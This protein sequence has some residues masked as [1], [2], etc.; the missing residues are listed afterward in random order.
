ML[1][2]TSIGPHRADWTIGFMQAPVREMFSRGQEKLVVLACLLA[3]AAAFASVRGQWPVLLLDDLPSELD[4]GHLA[5]TLDWLAAIPVQ[6]FITGTAPLTL[7][8]SSPRETRVFHVEQ[9]QIGR[10]L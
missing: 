1:G 8:A 9:G 3:Q 10:L 5:A 7:P 6:A 4:T 2:H